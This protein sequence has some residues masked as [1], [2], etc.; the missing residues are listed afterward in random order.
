[1]MDVNLTLLA[2]ALALAPADDD[3]DGAVS[4]TVSGKVVNDE[5]AAGIGDRLEVAPTPPVLRPPS[6]DGG[7]AITVEVGDRLDADGSDGET[8]EEAAEA[9]AAALAAAADEIDAPSS[10]HT[11]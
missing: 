4:G 7:A 6:R 5:A 3:G 10:L 1:M 2:A 11:A 9:A 8:E